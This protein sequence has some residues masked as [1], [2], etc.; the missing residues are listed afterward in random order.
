MAWLPVLCDAEGVPTLVFCCATHIRT[1]S[2]D[3]TTT[4]IITHKI[5]VTTRNLLFIKSTT[6]VLHNVWQTSAVYGKSQSTQAGSPFHAIR[7]DLPHFLQ[8][9]LFA[10]WWMCCLLPP[11]LARLDLT[12]DIIT[13]FR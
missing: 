5:T 11:I 10:C 8:M 3:A 13:T 6:E 4:I 2:S 12:F 9:A 1:I 7:I